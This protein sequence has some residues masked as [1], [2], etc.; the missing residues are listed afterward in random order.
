VIRGGG[1]KWLSAGEFTDA[2]HLNAALLQ[3]A[4]VQS[5][6]I[7]EYGT[8]IDKLASRLYNLIVA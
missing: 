2:F 1:T 8:N 3:H 4:L 5:G 6:R 7:A